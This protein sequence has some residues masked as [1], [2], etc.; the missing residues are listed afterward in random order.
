[1]GTE[2]SGTP[3]NPETTSVPLQA[4]P[5]GH[6]PNAGGISAKKGDFFEKFP[7]NPKRRCLNE[8]HSSAS[9]P[10]SGRR[11]RLG[12]FAAGLNRVV[13]WSR[14]PHAKA[15]VARSPTTYHTSPSGAPRRSGVRS[16]RGHSKAAPT[17]AAQPKL[18]WGHGGCQAGHLLPNP[19]PGRCDPISH[20]GKLRPRLHLWVGIH[21][22][23][24]LSRPRGCRLGLSSLT[25]LAPREGDAGVCPNL[26][27]GSR[28]PKCGN[29]LGSPS[30]TVGSMSLS[31][32]FVLKEED[33]SGSGKGQQTACPESHKV[34]KRSRA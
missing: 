4:T 5:I 9:A 19:Q 20:T 34:P 23:Q 1:M 30:Q 22:C 10:P 14:N 3:A 6:T 13:T 31:P 24:R 33:T 2:A 18:V 17:G 21:V 7:S 27:P 16:L 15:F 25:S 12:S 32:A 28:R 11:K 29:A 26:S 8:N